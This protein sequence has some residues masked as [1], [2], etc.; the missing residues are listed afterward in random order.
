MSICHS[1][2]IGCW[3]ISCPENKDNLIDSQTAHSKRLR[4]YKHLENKGMLAYFY[5]LYRTTV[6]FL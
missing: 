1:V 2:G 6:V 4:G 3:S 5:A